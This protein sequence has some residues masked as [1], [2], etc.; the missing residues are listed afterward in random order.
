LHFKF[1][2]IFVVKAISAEKAVKALVKEYRCSEALAKE[3][4]REGICHGM[5]PGF[6]PG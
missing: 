1:F 5:N 4:G 6:I 2:P 3:E